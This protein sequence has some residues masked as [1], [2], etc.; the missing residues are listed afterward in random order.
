MVLPMEMLV[1]VDMSRGP[2]GD[3]LERIELR[4]GL[5][6]HLHQVDQVSGERKAQTMLSKFPALR[7]QERRDTVLRREGRQVGKVQVQPQP[8]TGIVRATRCL[9]R[10]GA[11]YH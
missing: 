5:R 7:V 11:G 1:A 10:G 3:R 2:A 9:C 6:N 4:L 8:Q